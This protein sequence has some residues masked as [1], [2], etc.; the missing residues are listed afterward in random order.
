MPTYDYGC[1]SCDRVIEVVHK[2][3]ENPEITC[4]DCHSV[5]EKRISPG[6]G[7]VFKGSGFYVNDYPSI[8]D[9]GKDLPKDAVKIKKDE[10]ST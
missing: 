1:S 5:M 8:R 4:L 9:M 7:I 3:T 10:S 6:A 2:M